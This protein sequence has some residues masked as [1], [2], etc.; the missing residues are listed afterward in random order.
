[1]IVSI[2]LNGTG[3]VAET[4]H[5][6][7]RAYRQTYLCPVASVLCIRTAFSNSGESRGKNLRKTDL[8]VDFSTA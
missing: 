6:R 1:M 3:V 4:V 2:N 7:D 8:P 5:D